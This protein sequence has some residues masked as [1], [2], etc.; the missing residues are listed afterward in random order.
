MLLFVLSEYGVGDL[1]FIIIRELMM[2]A[3]HFKHCV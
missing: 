3:M 1:L 2:L